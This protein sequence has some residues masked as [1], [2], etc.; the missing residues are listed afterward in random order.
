MD[1]DPSVTTSLTEHTASAS[2][3]VAAPPG[4]VF[5]YLR[6]PA[7][8][9]AISGDATVIRDVKGPDLLEAESRF[10]MKMRRGPLRYR[11]TSTVVEY[12]RDRV[13]AWAH[14]GGHRWRW[15]LQPDGA[16]GTVVT[17]TYDQSTARLRALNRLMGYPKGHL[18][19]VAES[20]ANVA[21]RF[22][23]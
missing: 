7:N 15:E 14:L 11:M 20:V 6:N 2:T 22:A 21:R 1:S 3:T 19:N 18:D 5:D 17:E 13:I 8:H 23:A 10:T 16:G 9:A 12:D 4:A